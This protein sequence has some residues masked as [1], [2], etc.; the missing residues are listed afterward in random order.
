[1][2]TA[3]RVEGTL[4]SSFQN[5]KFTN[6][7]GSAL[8]VGRNCSNITITDSLFEN[9]AEMELILVKLISICRLEMSK[10]QIQKYAVVVINF[11]EV[12]GFGW[13]WLKTVKLNSAKSANFLTQE[14]PSVGSG[15]ILQQW[16]GTIKFRIIISTM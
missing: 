11:M 8:G 15:T 5:C 4:D 12:W 9:I 10:F 2:P 6:L 14:S 1:M 13:G 7:G 3:V 16:H